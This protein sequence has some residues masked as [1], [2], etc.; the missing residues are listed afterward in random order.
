VHKLDNKVFEAVGFLCH[1]STNLIT[2]TRTDIACQVDN[3]HVPEVP[4][5]LADK[6][7]AWQWSTVKQFLQHIQ[8]AN[9]KYLLQNN[10]KLEKY[11]ISH[12]VRN[13]NQ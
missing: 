5:I 13:S 7:N 8:S 4:G 3:Q 6:H 9:S 12:N 11:K 2:G 10:V 1:Y